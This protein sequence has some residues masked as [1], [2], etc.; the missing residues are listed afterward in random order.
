MILNNIIGKVRRT[1]GVGNKPAR[2]LSWVPAAVLD[3][4]L[5]PLLL[6]AVV[7]VHRRQTHILRHGAAL[8]PM[9]REL[10]LGLGVAAVDRVRVTSV[11]VIATPLPRWM[12]VLAQRAGRQSRHIA[13]MTLGHGIVIR[14]DYL[15][16]TRL[17]AHELVHVR[18]YERLGGVARFLRAYLRECVW[19]GYPHGALECEARAAE[20]HGSAQGEDVIPYRNPTVDI[21]LPPRTS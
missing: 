5:A 4:L 13:G 15:G 21:A 9:Q 17:L 7:W 2:A 10:A 16:D 12:H 19:P 8:N 6:C 3:V 20:A 18:Q 14:A 11:E 1:S